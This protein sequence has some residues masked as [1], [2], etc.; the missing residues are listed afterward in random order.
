VL[1]RDVINPDPFNFP[2]TYRARSFA[3]EYAAAPCFS[4]IQRP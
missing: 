3:F 1:L 2:H 4:W